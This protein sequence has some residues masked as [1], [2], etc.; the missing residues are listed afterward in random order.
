MSYLAEPTSITDYGIVKVGDHIQVSGGVISLLQD[1]SP[2]ASV[3][4]TSV[5]ADVVFSDAEPVVT[6][7][8]P[9]GGPGIDVVGLVDGG[10]DVSFTVN[11]TGVLSIT[12]GPGISIDQSTGDIYISA[13]GADLI[14]VYGTTVDYTASP[15]DEYIGVSSSSD[16][17]I[18]LP[19]GADG[20]V[21][22][23]KDEYGN[24]AGTIIIQPSLG[25]MIDGKANYRIRSP[26][27]GVNLVSR[28][29]NWW[30]I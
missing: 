1:V 24:N 9:Q 14:S 30:L 16:V 25:E 12:A 4:F 17:T 28:A 29:G 8:T 22:T 11:N 7:V 26:Y 20:R 27:Q 15:D 23:I 6:S 18:T 10:P 21:Y 5:T 13:V 19:P 3:T 2:D